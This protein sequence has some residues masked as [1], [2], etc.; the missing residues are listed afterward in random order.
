MPNKNLTVVNTQD[1]KVALTRAKNLM[2]VA[3][4]LL[5]KSR[6]KELKSAKSKE[7]VYD[8]WIDRLWEWAD[9]NDIPDLHLVVSNYSSSRYWKGLPRDKEKLLTL[10]ELNLTG[11]RL[12]KLPKEIGNLTNLISLNLCCNELRELPNEI[13]NL[14]NLT[15]LD[16]SLNKLKELP[17]SICNIT[18]LSKLNLLERQLK[19]TSTNF[20]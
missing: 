18:N 20:V 3:N 4:K 5:A 11:N 9:E 17:K 10:T 7:L 1:T 14:I 15:K 6:A 8:S 2:G 16:L 12:A 13:G 19:E